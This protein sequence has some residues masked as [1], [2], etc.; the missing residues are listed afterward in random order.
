MKAVFDVH[1]SG[2]RESR[3][4]IMGVVLT[5]GIVRSNDA[6]RVELP[7]GRSVRWSRSDRALR[8]STSSHTEGRPTEP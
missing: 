7:R 6:I 4:G 3:A 1:E 8:S 5:G 2:Q